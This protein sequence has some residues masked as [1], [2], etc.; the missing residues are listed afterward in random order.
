MLIFAYLAQCRCDPKNTVW[1]F[2]ALKKIVDTLVLHDN[3]PQPLMDLTVYESSRDRFDQDEVAQ[4]AIKL[5]FGE[6]ERLRVPYDADVPED[7]IV[8]AWKDCL[9]TSWLLDSE[10]AQQLQR[11]ASNAL[12]IISEHRRSPSLRKFWEE[13]KDLMTPDRAYDTL[14]VPKDV[15]DQMLLM[16]FSMRV[17]KPKCLASTYAA[18]VGGAAITDQ[19]DAYRIG[20]YCSGSE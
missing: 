16:I 3:C 12:R 20:S 10:S 8:S 6:E 15:D 7:F 4:A 5:G 14:E 18:V 11:D 9:K 17:C 19:Q 1:Y 2:T 13:S